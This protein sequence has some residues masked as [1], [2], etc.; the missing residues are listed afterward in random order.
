MAE[1]PLETSYHATS[2]RTGSHTTA[3]AG[4]AAKHQLRLECYT[5]ADDHRR[6]GYCGGAHF[7]QDAGTLMRKKLKTRFVRAWKR[8]VTPCSGSCNPV[9]YF[10]PET[11]PLEK[12]KGPAGKSSFSFQDQLRRQSQ[13]RSYHRGAAIIY[14]NS[15][16]VACIRPTPYLM[17][18]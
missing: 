15:R 7:H 4:S 8:S 5:F 17:H 13:A 14:A 9:I 3:S 6:W 11:N 10:K 1:M 2:Q 18:M 12:K 16:F